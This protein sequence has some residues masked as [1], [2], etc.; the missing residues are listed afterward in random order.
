MKDDLISRSELLKKF[1][2]PDDLVHAP[3][4]H[5]H[6]VRSIINDAPSCTDCEHDDNEWYE[7]P[8]DDCVNNFMVDGT[9]NNWEKA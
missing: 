1:P 7:E 6:T 3:M 8:C 4:L 9:K 2:I 5:I